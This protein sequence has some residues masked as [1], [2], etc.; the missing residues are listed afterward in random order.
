MS[1]NGRQRLTS[2]KEIAAHVGRDVRTVLRWE[3]DRG[4]PIHRVPGATGRVVFAYT[5]ELDAWARG[6]SAAKAGQPPPIPGPVTETVAPPPPVAARAAPISGRRRAAAAS[7]VVV[8]I[9]AGTWGVREW[10][11]SSA[12]LDIVP[13]ETAIVARTSDGSERWRYSFPEGE[14]AVH[15]T[16]RAPQ[17]G[18]MAGGDVIAATSYS[19]QG[20][21]QQGRSGELLRFTRRGALK[22]VFRFDDRLAFANGPYAPPW[23]IR[24]FRVRSTGTGLRIAVAGHHFEWWPSIVTIL[25]E[26]WKRIGTFINAG[27]VERL[28]WISDERLLIAGFANEQDGGMIAL[29]DTKALDGQSPTARDGGFHC[30]GCGG[31]APLRYVVM[32]RSEINRASGAPFNRVVLTVKPDSVL[33]R[34][35]EMSANAAAPDVVYEFTPNLDLIRA[36][37]SDRYWE[38]HREL[39]VAGKIA[40]TRAQCP[41]RAGPKQILVWEPESGW[42]TMPI[43]AARGRSHP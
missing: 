7:A 10:K 43:A 30:A 21:D 6:D 20:S 40:H 32:P 9:A 12:P 11:A 1:E 28:H 29:L 27:W 22:S 25:D 41:D 17:F 18:E 42:V 38:M 37:F 23:V 35:I 2:W 26:S 16:G 4:L 14:K 31:G 13:T 33:A 39:E 24:D 3:K 36:S 34:T 19:V 5:D 15:L 8:A